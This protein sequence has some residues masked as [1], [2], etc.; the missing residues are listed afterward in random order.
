MDSHTDREPKPNTESKS[1]RK[2]KPELDTV[3]IKKKFLADKDTVHDSD[4]ERSDLERSDDDDDDIQ[5]L[6][7]RPEP[8]LA[9]SAPQHAPLVHQV[10]HQ[11][12]PQDIIDN[13]CKLLC[14]LYLS[15]EQYEV[16]KRVYLNTMLDKTSRT[17]NGVLNRERS[18][19]PGNPNLAFKTYPAYPYMMLACLTIM[20]TLFKNNGIML[21]FSEYLVKNDISDQIDYMSNGVEWKDEHLKVITSRIMALMFEIKRDFPECFN[22]IKKKFSSNRTAFIQAMYILLGCNLHTWKGDIILHNSSV[23]LQIVN[24][25]LQREIWGCT[26][27]P[28]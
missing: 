28:K 12:V 24:I 16:C 3:N 5:L 8:L 6:P 10:V 23:E 25:V 15:T 13:I 19:Y 27:K 9:L 20:L 2:R 26:I 21:R 7:P 1:E 18:D 14:F 4:L 17:A 11:V 22:A